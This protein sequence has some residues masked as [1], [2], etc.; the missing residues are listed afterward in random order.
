MQWTLRELRTRLCCEMG[1]V[2]RQQLQEETRVVLGE[3][4]TEDV[5]QPLKYFSVCV[6]V[7]VC[8]C[9][10]MWAIT[11][12]TENKFVSN[13]ARACRMWISATVHSLQLQ[14]FSLHVEHR[15]ELVTLSLFYIRGQQR[16]HS[17]CM[18]LMQSPHN[19]SLWSQ[20]KQN[21]CQIK[22]FLGY[23]ADF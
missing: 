13:T 6:C 1:R 18:I 15:I 8:V 7:C 11:Q 17:K 20:Q 23:N 12:Q 21:P 14:P 22:A 2:W 10:R 9:V 4:W 3:M 16:V 19:T 5:L